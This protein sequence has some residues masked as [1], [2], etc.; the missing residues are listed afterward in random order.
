MHFFNNRFKPFFDIRDTRAQL[1][2]LRLN[3]RLHDVLARDV[4][5]GFCSVRRKVVS[6]NV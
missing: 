5:E 2:H 4:L 3:L 6:S 1:K